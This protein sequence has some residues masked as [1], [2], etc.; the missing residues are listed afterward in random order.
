MAYGVC[1]HRR[2][3]AVDFDN[4]GRRI[5]DRGG[6]RASESSGVLMAYSECAMDLGSD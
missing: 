6:G 4:F 3:V 2:G 1:L 5:L